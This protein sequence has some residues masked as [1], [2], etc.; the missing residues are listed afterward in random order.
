MKQNNKVPLPI[1]E[2]L[3]FIL[4]AVKNY[5]TI[6]IK[7]SPGSGKTTR[8]PS[9]LSQ[10]LN[11]KVVVL[12]PRRLAAKLAAQRISDENNLK[13]GK[14][15]GYQFRFEKNLSTDSRLMFFTEG[16]FLKVLSSSKTFDNVEI[17]IIDE[18]HER[19]IETDLALGLL[20]K[21]QQKRKIKIILMSATMDV[22]N[23]KEDHDHKVIEINVPIHPVKISY[24]PNQTS[25]LNQPLE[26]KVKNALEFTQGDTLVFL[27]GMREII[28]TQKILENLKYEIFILHSDVSGEEQSKVIYPS[29]KRKIILST[30]IAESSITIPGIE[31]V[32]DSGIQRSITYSSWNGLKYLKDMP[33]TKSSA[34]QRAH[35]AGRTGPGECIRLYSEFD[36]N[37]R[38]EN[39]EPKILTSDLT[40]TC[41]YLKSIQEIPIWPTLPPQDKWDKAEDVLERIGATRKGLISDIGKEMLKYPLDSRL[42]RSLIAGKRFKKSEQEK[43]LRFICN[44]IEEDNHLYHKLKDFLKEENSIEGNWEMAL[45][46]GFIDQIAKYRSNHHDFIHF[47]GKILKANPTIKN[48]SS[49]LYIIFDITKKQEVKVTTPIEES[50]LWEMNPSPLMEEEDIIVSEEIKIR[51]KLKLGSIVLEEQQIKQNWSELSEESKIK[52]SISCEQIKKNKIS[53]F[54]ETPFYGRLHLW[55]AVKQIKLKEIVEN[56]LM[57]EYFEENNELSLANFDHLFKR[58]LENSCDLKNIEEELPTKLILSGKKEHKVHYPKGMEPFLE[59]PIQDFYGLKESPTIMRGQIKLI[60]KLLGPNKRPIQITKDLKSFWEITYKELKKQYERDYPKHYW[61]DNPKTSKPFLLKS[62][63]TKA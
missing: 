30:N 44:E 5:S 48:Y 56:Y 31:V 11:S 62:H 52:I 37:E 35:R 17:F 60:I 36:Y 22:L 57:R 34:I 51:K 25:V 14:E 9:Y 10:K 33:I 28:N 40:D 58:Y 45:I 29:K 38:K 50:W 20:K 15:I 32:I 49:G 6:I 24:L 61:P 18:F 4:Q 2:K 13:L 55:S 53:E 54:L 42:A 26:I 1:D 8:I 43:L 23:I 63:L 19:H 21:I 39:S 3:D 47:S 16:T 41:L 7:S 12:E 46:S 59:A 27:P